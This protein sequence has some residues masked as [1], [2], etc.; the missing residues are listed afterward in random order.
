[1]SDTADA[2]VIG[3]GPNGLVAANALAEAGWDTVVLEAADEVGGAVRSGNVTAPDF[4]TDLFSAFYPL[5]AASPVLR[6]LELDRHGLHWVK[7]PAVLGHALPDG[8]AVVLHDQPEATAASVSQFA[9]ADG[10]QEPGQS[11]RLTA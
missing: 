8:R 7:A 2:V 1:M 6:G 11:R 9:P 4:I 3:A 5:A 10:Q